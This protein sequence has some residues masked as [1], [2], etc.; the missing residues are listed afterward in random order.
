MVSSILRA[1]GGGIWVQLLGGQ[2]ANARVILILYEC[3]W[4]EPA[5]SLVLPAFDDTGSLDSPPRQ[6]VYSPG[7][8]LPPWVT[9]SSFVAGNR[10][11]DLNPTT[12]SSPLLFLS[13][14]FSGPPSDLSA[15][16]IIVIIIFG[17]HREK[18]IFSNSGLTNCSWVVVRFIKRESF[19]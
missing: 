8:M 7:S 5:V 15:A 4:N 10:E 18:K 11:A 12:F 2:G 14:L 3:I 9:A 6:V 16:L 1:W 17:A 19:G 13:F